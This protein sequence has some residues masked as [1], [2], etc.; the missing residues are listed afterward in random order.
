VSSITN[1]GA[2]Y[3]V[4]NSEIQTFK[5]CRR[6]WWFNYYRRLQPK[7]KKVSGP[8]ALGS[9]VHNALEEYYANGVP[10][11]EAYNT[12][13]EKDRVI[14]LTEWL[15]VDALDS[16][17]E[18]GRI[19]L[20]GYLEWIAEEGIDSDYDIISNEETLVMP[21]LNGEVELQGKLDMR[22]RRKSDGTRLIR[23]FKT[24][25]QSF[26]QFASTLHLNEQVLTYLTLEA[27]HNTEEDR[28]DGAIFTLFKKVK[29]TATAKPPFYDQIEISHNVFTLRSFWKR[30]H[31]S[32][33]DLMN[34]KK[35]LDAGVDH[36]IVAYP[37]PSNDCTWKCPYFAICPLVDDGSAVEAAINDLFEVGNP[38][39]RYVDEKK[40]SE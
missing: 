26:T 31:G 5:D 40:G 36:R 4:S 7:K 2:P 29:R 32:V 24:V 33:T 3:R 37:K 9:R 16:E 34:T 13:L 22:V 39:S 6:R 12:F 19:M 11:L 14:A 28:S 21:I 8:L 35:A 20:E 27:Y 38:N 17:G 30:L 18:L 25:G 1:G 23:D 15:D 10:L